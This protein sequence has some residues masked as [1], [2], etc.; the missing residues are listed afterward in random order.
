MYKEQTCKIF[1]EDAIVENELFRI[2]YT[3]LVEEIK[4]KFGIEPKDYEILKP[5][6]QSIK[7]KLKQDF[8]MDVLH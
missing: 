8:M 6:Q 4:I 2:E 3:K 7:K 1:V 5:K